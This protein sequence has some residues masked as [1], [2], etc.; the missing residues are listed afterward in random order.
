MFKNKTLVIVAVIGILALL[1]GAA[2]LSLSKS[3]KAT[4]PAEK[5]TVTQ[6]KV[7]SSSSMTG[8]LKSLL[9]GGKTQICSISYPDN[10]GTGTIY[11]ADKKFSGDF[12]MKADDGKVTVGHMISDGIYMYVWSTAT[13][14]GIKIK[15]DAA[16]NAAG[17]TQPGSVDINQKVNLNCS[18]WIA[19][20]SKFNVPSNI[21]FSD[22]SNIMQNLPKAPANS[23]TPE[24]K[25]Q[26]EGN[27]SPCDQITDATAKA[28]CAKALSGQQ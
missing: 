28:A 14:M 1:G 15:L 24:A 7:S 11:V 13:P 23:S 25:T 8:S 10:K 12:T 19:D 21:Q 17:K 26:T 18:P 27:G 9:T 2:Y 4:T 16:I 22:L 5:I 20:Q 6:P 3:S